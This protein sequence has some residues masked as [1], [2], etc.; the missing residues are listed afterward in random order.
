VCLDYD[1]DQA[2][3]IGSNYTLRVTLCDSSGANLSDRQTELVAVSIDGT[4]QPEP[5]DS[6]KANSAYTFRY[7]S[8]GNRYVYNLDTTNLG[9]LTLGVRHTLDFSVTSADGSVSY[10]SAPFTVS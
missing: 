7:Q 3:R 5:N 10:G 6:G 8:S 4:R 9:D 1:P 2:K